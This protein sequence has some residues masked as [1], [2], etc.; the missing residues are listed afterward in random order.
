MTQRRWRRTKVVS[1]FMGGIILGVGVIG[2]RPEVGFADPT[3]GGSG[4]HR[5]HL[6]RYPPTLRPVYVALFTVA[7]C[8]PRSVPI[9]AGGVSVVVLFVATGAN[10]VFGWLGG[11]NTLL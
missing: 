8:Q 1:P 4:S 6:S 9:W 7:T 5:V 10:S 11:T 3:P 2:R